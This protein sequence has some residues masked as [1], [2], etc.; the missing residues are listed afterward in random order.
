M[1]FDKP[2][3]TRTLGTQTLGTQT[4]STQT[5][6]VLS[7]LL[8]TGCS[9]ALPQPLWKE[10]V[11]GDGPGDPA[12]L[13]RDVVLV[14][15]L[16]KS[17]MG[18]APEYTIFGKTYNVLDTARDFKEWGVASWYGKKFHGRATASGEIYDMHLLTAAHR[19]LPLPTFVRVTRVDNDLSVVVKVN[20]RGPFVEDRVID[21]SYAAAA[22]L[23]LLEDGKAEVFI[24]ALSSHDGEILPTVALSADAD[25]AGDSGGFQLVQAG[26]FAKRDNAERMVARLSAETDLPIIIDFDEPSKLHRVRIG[27]ISGS[28]LINETLDMLKRSGIEG[29]R[30]KAPS[31]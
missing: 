23:D 14:Q 28:R 20:D 10:A 1:I 13:D 27:P 29:Y 31:L 21:L 3:G 16:P 30:V 19:N 4:L 24:E 18:N 8:I 11:K 15:N 9:G 2:F 26:A 25:S 22:K 17:A 12:L 5:L 6:L 7:A